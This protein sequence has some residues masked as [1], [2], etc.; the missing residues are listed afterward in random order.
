[1]WLTPGQVEAEKA[2]AEVQKESTAA[3]TTKLTEL[4][5]QLRDPAQREDAAKAVAEISDP[6]VVPAVFK[7]MLTAK[8]ADPVH[9]V[10]ILGQ[11]DSLQASRLL[12]VL[13][14]WSD[15][16]E[17]R[18]KATT[19]LRCRDPRQYAYSLIEHINPPLP[20]T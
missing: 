19:A 7:A 13:A 4:K 16:A 12:A 11:V 9:A 8:D 20:Y 10:Q 6:R 2:E 5:K 18:D 15:S 17:A 14:I 3:W 1:R